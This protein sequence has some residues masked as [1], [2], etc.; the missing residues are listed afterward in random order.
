MFAIS[1]HENITA[2]SLRKF[3]NQIITYGFH[4]MQISSRNKDR[5]HFKQIM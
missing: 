3:Q 5:I 4:D 1:C 2:P